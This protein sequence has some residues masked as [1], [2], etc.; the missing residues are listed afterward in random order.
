[1]QST[2]HGEAHHFAWTDGYDIFIAPSIDD[3]R[4]MQREHTGEDYNTCP[5]V[6]WSRAN[7][8]RSLTIRL[9]D[10]RGDV[11]QTIADWIRESGPGFL[12][13]TEW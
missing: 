2:G 3:A 13:S 10:G 1:M 8:E 7:P 11:T 4:R 6:E 9:D 5:L 12:C